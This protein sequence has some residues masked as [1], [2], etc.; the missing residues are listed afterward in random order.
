MKRLPMIVLAAAIALGARISLAAEA[1]VV[2]GVLMPAWVERDARRLP[3]APGMELKGGDELRTGAGARVYVKFSE[4]SL[5]QLGENA[6]LRLQDLAPQRGGL[7]KATMNVLE[8]AFRF[9]TDV[10]KKERHREVNITIRTVTAGIRGTDLWGKSTE[11]RQIVCLIEG[12]IEVGAQGEAAVTMD[13]PLQFYQRVRGQTLP[14]GKV[15]DAQLAEWSK[16]TAIE[17]GRGAA[18]RGGRWTITLASV[19]TQDAA[20]AV[21]DAVREAGYAATILPVKVGEKTLYHVRIAQL[22]SKADAETLAG[23]LRGK[24]GIADPKV[25]G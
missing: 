23:H 22:P 11:E 1:A 24:Y 21:Y 25:S 7:F 5:V 19:E 14:V 20:L 6:S 18:R 10:L 13:Q 9:T 4:G 8:G 3:L 16:E 17:T 2:E 12:R 15:A